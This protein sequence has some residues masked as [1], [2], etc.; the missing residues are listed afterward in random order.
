MRTLFFSRLACLARRL[1][2]STVGLVLSTALLACSSGGPSVRPATTWSSSSGGGDGEAVVTGSSDTAAPA[3]PSATR[4]ASEPYARAEAEAAPAERPGLGT[5]WGETRYSPVRDV[6]FERG[7]DTPMFLGSLHYNDAP[8]VEAM[9][10][11]IV[12]LRDGEPVLRY[13]DGGSSRTRYFG[14][15]TV[16]ILD[17]S[18]RP[19]PAYHLGERVLVVGSAGQRYTL[20]VANRTGQRFELVASVDGLDV[21]D[22]RPASLDKRGYVVGPHATV[23]IDGFRRSMSEVAAF[24][25]GT[26]KDSYAAKSAE[27]GAKHVGVVGVALFT[28][29]GTRI[30]D[31]AAYDYRPADLD[32]EARRREQADPFPGRFAAP[33]P[34]QPLARE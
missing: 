22:G 3:S 34:P 16:S 12:R 24:R 19:L 18:G 1:G 32:D 28:E 5:E 30:Q 29:R 21:V 27:F 13:S 15:L 10:D 23:H 11:R 14:G 6:G 8:G 25:F 9:R 26:V 7:S 2:C 31:F 20:A 4:A 17:E 33:P